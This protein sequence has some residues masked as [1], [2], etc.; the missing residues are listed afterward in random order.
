MKARG[1]G[2]SSPGDDASHAWTRSDG[3]SRQSSDHSQMGGHDGRARRRSS[4]ADGQRR[5]SDRERARPADG[6][7]PRAPARSQDQCARAV[8]CPGSDRSGASLVPVGGGRGHTSGRHIRGGRVDALRHRPRRR[9][10]SGR[11]GSSRARPRDRVRHGRRARITHR[12]R[13]S[14]RAI[15]PSAIG[16]H[17]VSGPGHHYV[18]VARSLRDIIPVGGALSALSSPF[19]CH[20]SEGPS[21]PS[22]G[23]RR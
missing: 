8:E 2:L 4:E 10:R 14:L 21:C 22:A 18:V 5:I 1:L 6:P 12:C 7:V 17:D 16:R 13:T 19:R 15:D 20:R 3:A 23:D 9:A 11:G